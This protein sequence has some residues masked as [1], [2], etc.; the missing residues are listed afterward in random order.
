VISFLASSVCAPE[1]R[2][3]EAVCADE[4]KRIH[5]QPKTRDTDLFFQ[6]RVLL[7]GFDEV[8]NDVETAREDQRKEESETCEICISLRAGSVILVIE[9]KC[10]V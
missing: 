10:W 2:D 8:K 6:N 3:W 7:L 9:S 5:G 1:L 4:I